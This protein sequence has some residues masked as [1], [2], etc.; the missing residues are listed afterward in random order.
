MVATKRERANIV[1]MQVPFVDLKAQYREIQDDVLAAISDALEGMELFL[2]PN[3]RAFE[4]EFA[5]YCRTRF[6][7][8]VGSGTDALYLALKACG[9]GPGDEVITVPYT[10]F[11]TAEAIRM[12]GAIPV[13]VDVEPDTY[14]L[15]PAKLPGALTARTRAI[16]PV[17]L[18]GQMADMDA[19]MAFARQHGLVVVEDACQAHGAGDRGQRAGSV[20]DAAAFSFYMSK[21]LGGYGEAGAVTTGSRAVAEAV[22]LLR[23]HGSSRKYEHQEY[24]V[25][26]RLDELQAAILRVKLRK[27]EEWN[28]RRRAHAATYAW[29]LEGLDVGLPIVRPGASHVYHLYVVRLKD[30]DRVRGELADRGVSTGVHYPIPIHR[31][32]AFTDENA[33]IAGDLSVSEALAEQV[34]SLPMYPEL[35]V[36]QLH[37]VAG[38]LRDCLL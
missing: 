35:E 14:T 28:E 32:A 37:S 6:S 33:R 19:I 7:I 31:Q 9:V 26:S 22:R 38:C 24:G 21:N 25:N 36:G 2:G 12:L 8:G 1:P 13:F 4:A 16:V 15:D 30:R 3:V 5:A 18:Y 29:L 17:H 10:F 20:G 23:D 27:L 11:A 34:I